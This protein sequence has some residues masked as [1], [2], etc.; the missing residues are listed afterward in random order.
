M[1]GEQKVIKLTDKTPTK[2]VECSHP[3]CEQLLEVTKFYAPAKAR[4]PKHAGVRAPRVKREAEVRWEQVDREAK[5]I[6]KSLPEKSLG[7]L[8][9][10][11]DDT[12]MEILAISEHFGEVVFG[13]P[14]CQLGVSMT[15]WWRVLQIKSIPEDLRPMVE[16]FNQKQQILATRENAFVR[17]D[18]EERSDGSKAS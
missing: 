14:T 16:A 7:G 13:C 15:A 8:R 5:L 1:Q 2:I 4:C 17:V 6:D 9:C 18:S 11:F 10:P 3:D 12:P